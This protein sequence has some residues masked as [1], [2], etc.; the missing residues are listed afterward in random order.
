M[1]SGFSW[2]NSDAELKKK[3]GGVPRNEGLYEPKFRRAKAN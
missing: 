3:G 2:Q 1:E